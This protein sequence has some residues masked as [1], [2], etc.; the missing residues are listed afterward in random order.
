MIARRKLVCGFLAL[1]LAFAVTGRAAGSE[2]KDKKDEGSTRFIEVPILTVNILRSNYSR[3]KVE[4]SL[5]LDVP[6][7]DLFERAQESLP[8]LRAAY[9]QTLLTYM[10]DLAPGTPPD[11]GRLTLALQRATDKALGRA[12]ARVLLGSV[13][14]S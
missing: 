13:V 5:G 7:P 9:V 4:I 14:V 3:G 1:S 10:Y 6:N 8:R 11:I 2:S 12:G